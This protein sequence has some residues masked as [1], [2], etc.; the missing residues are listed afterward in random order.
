MQDAILHWAPYLKVGRFE[1]IC[2][3][4]AVEYIF[5]CPNITEI[6]RVLHYAL[7]LVGFNY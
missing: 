3:H 7:D 2:D 6:H 1:V 5:N 4:K